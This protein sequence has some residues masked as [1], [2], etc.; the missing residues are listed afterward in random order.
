MKLCD[1]EA[2]LDSLRRNQGVVSDNEAFERE[3]IWMK[4][5]MGKLER[6]RT[7]LNTNYDSLE[8]DYQVLQKEMEELHKQLTVARN[9]QPTPS[10]QPTPVSQSK[11]SVHNSM[12]SE[13][14]HEERNDLKQNT[15]SSES[16]INKGENSLC[17]RLIKVE[18]EKNE[19]KL[20]QRALNV[21][22]EKRLCLIEEELKVTNGKVASLRQEL[23]SV[24]AS[25][26]M[27]STV[28]EMNTKTHGAIIVASQMLSMTI[29]PAVVLC[30]NF[31]FLI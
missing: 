18:R 15:N 27:D 20:K 4:E 5:K 22:A 6:E 11:I 23:W 29:T 16:S 21:P 28:C 24:Q 30:W 19:L 10:M 17:E 2:V 13:S 1:T 25:K 3:L 12:S 7:L 26:C 9:T 14:A 31:K 8:Q